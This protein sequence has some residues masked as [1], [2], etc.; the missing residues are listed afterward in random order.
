MPR[1]RSGIAIH[2]YED[3]RSVGMLCYCLNFQQVC[4]YLLTY[5]KVYAA[6]RNRDTTMAFNRIPLGTLYSEIE[7]EN[8]KKRQKEWEDC[9]KAAMPK[10]FFPNVEDRLKLQ[11]DVK[12][13]FTA[14]VTGHGKI[15]AYLHRFKIL[16]QGTCT[17]KKGDQTT[18]HF[19]NHCT[20]LQT[21]RELL[22]R[23]VSKSG[24]WP[25]SK[26]ELI[27]KH[28][29]PFLTFTKSIDFDQL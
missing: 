15:R 27:K 7:E 16:E 6:A 3:S 2:C 23:N 18:D 20:L 28:L 19:I 13:I 17:C 25:A 26:H 1:N 11:I 29:K 12:P 14:L 8:L 22:R 21:Q 4:F 10:Q 9:T 24:N 5:V